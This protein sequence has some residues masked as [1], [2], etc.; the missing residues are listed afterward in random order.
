MINERDAKVR[1]KRWNA[2]YFVGNLAA[3]WCKGFSHYF[4]GA[5]GEKQRNFADLR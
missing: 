1:K 5:G 3:L 4:D 2:Y